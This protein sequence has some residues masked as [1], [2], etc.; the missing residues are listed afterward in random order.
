MTELHAKIIVI[1]NALEQQIAKRDVVDETGIITNHL[2]AAWEARDAIK[3]L[4]ADKPIT[5]DG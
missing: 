3:A 4:F 2:R 5:I 1:L